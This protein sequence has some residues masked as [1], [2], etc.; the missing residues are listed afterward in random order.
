MHTSGVA[1]R[2]TD[3]Y[4]AERQRGTRVPLGWMDHRTFLV[5][6]FVFIALPGAGGADLI[7]NHHA[8]WQRGIGVLL[9]VLVGVEVV[10]YVRWWR[11]PI[12]QESLDE[13][14]LLRSRWMFD[15]R[16]RTPSG[17]KVE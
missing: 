5:L 16:P 13:L 8:V 2:E 7:F 12:D 11:R 9:L 10:L 4:H 3:S 6:F 14:N 17:P 1:R 15:R